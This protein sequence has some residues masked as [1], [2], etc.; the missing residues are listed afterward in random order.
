VL[1]EDRKEKLEIIQAQRDAIAHLKQKAV[2]P[3]DEGKKEH[4]LASMRHK[5]DELKILADI[6]DP[7]VKRRFE[8]GFG[9]TD[10]PVHVLTTC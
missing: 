3:Q 5:L 7:L 1:Q 9:M 8:D 4:R 10:I 6:N 2:A